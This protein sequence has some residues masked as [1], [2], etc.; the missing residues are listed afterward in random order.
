VK[1]YP[2]TIE[3]RWDILY[4]VYPEVYDTFSSFPYHPHAMGVLMTKFPVCGAT[5]LDIGS[6][7]GKSS[8]ALDLRWLTTPER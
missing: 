1:N 6:R 4:K 3:G 5:V 2:E 8:F 7:T